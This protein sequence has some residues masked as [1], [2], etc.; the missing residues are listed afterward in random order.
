MNIIELENRVGTPLVTKRKE[1]EAIN[2]TTK[3]NDK[4]VFN[5]YCAS[6]PKKHIHT[7]RKLQI[8]D[9]NAYN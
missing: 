5:L 9:D 3:L 6:G 2:T 8:D 4:N 1:K 7:H